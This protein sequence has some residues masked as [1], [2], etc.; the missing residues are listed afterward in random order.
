MAE[1]ATEPTFSTGWLVASYVEIVEVVAAAAALGF[2]RPVTTHEIA[3]AAA[4]KARGVAKTIFKSGV[5]YDGVIVPGMVVPGLPL[6]HVAVGVPVKEAKPVTVIDATAVD[7]AP[8]NPTVTVE[9]VAMTL[10]EKAME[11]ELKAPANMAGT[12]TPV[13][14][15]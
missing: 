4:S 14:V 15:S 1:T 9:A 7:D 10:D 2:V 12:G 6:V 8:V 3:P 5:V 13:I 11:A